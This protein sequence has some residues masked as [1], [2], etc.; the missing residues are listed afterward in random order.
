M[1]EMGGG[2]GGEVCVR[3]RERERNA[4]QCAVE[5][6]PPHNLVYSLACYPHCGGA[7]TTKIICDVTDQHWLKSGLLA[8][9]AAE[10][11]WSSDGQFS[12][13]STKHL[14][15]MEQENRP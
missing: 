12:G 14:P 13:P 1:K 15:V 6:T 9:R 8:A 11:Q 10:V 7:Y 3:E 4:N 2:G 5:W